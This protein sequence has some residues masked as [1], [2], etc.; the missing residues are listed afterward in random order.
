MSP[1]VVRGNDYSGK[2]SN[3]SVFRSPQCW[4]MC[5]FSSFLHVLFLKDGKSVLSNPRELMSLAQFVIAL[6]PVAH[7]A[8]VC[9]Y[10]RS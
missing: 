6:C 7:Y 9:L 2:S 3:S 4:S 8:Y 5:L 1:E 10:R